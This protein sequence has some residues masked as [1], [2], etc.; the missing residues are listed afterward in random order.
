MNFDLRLH[1]DLL[2]LYDGLVLFGVP[3][4]LLHLVAVLS[5]V[6]DLAYRRICIRG[7]FHQVQTRLLCQMNR[8]EGLHDTLLL[9][10]L[11]DETHLMC[12]NLP[13]DT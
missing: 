5:E 6:E 7:D 3:L 2:D 9:A 8:V 4:L 12:T 10:V 11:V 1:P 13:V